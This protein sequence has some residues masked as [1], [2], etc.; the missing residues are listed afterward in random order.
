M[1]SIGLPAAGV[2]V[3]AYRTPIVDGLFLATVATVTFAK[4]QW[5][6]AG[7]LQLS[8]VVTALFL[9]AFVWARLERRDGIAT[10]ASGVTLAFF[11]AFAVLYLIGFFNL[12]TAQALAQWTKGMIK[13]VLHFGFLVA[14]IA[15]V[16]R[17][18]ER[19]YWQ[20]LGVFCGGLALNGLYGLTQL[21]Y[22]ELTRGGNLDELFV[23]PVTGGDSRINIYGAI[24]GQN[25]YRVNAL[26][27]DPNHL[28][29]ELA[30]PILI[31]L[32]LYLRMER[33]HPWRRRV[34]ALIAFL[35]IVQLATLSR[36]G[37]LGLAAG[38]LVLAVPYHRLLL[39]ARF[40]VP[41]TLLVAAVVAFASQRGE[42][43]QQV[44][45][46][47]FS[48]EGGGSSTH[49]VVYSFIPDVL[50]MHPLFGLGLNN[51]SVYYEF[52]T[53]RTNFGPHSFYVALFVET[54]IV[55]ALLFA[56]FLVYLFRRCGATRRI[57]RALADLGDPVAA[58]VRPLGWGLTAALVA[59]LVSN[60][61][62]LTMTFYYFFVVA[63][64]VIVPP[65]VFGRRL[66][67]AP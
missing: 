41:L 27:G 33:S 19:F 55:G 16:A 56:V 54:G 50:A 58:R 2:A 30:V 67:R 46:S 45:R 23:Q 17:R 24:G 29:I 32:P 31:L 61:F 11:A 42:F 10:R 66:Q 38:L 47:R 22:A 18:G 28:G 15:L 9:V 35:A 49:F 62:Y 48:T 21:A 36:S 14:G 40:V 26:T 8:D 4:L 59:T 51:F 20:T 1:T 65:A 57:G 5:E 25:V 6:V 39:T 43:F 3:R 64:L 60:A 12:E 37:I 52:V 34:L 44:L 13:F 53:G 7:T 63:L